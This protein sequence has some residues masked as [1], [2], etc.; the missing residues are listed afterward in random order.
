MNPVNS[1]KIVCP[2]VYFSVQFVW[3]SM[4]AYVYCDFFFLSLT[5]FFLG[6]YFIFALFLLCS[7][8]STRW[9]CFTVYK[10]CSDRRDDRCAVFAYINAD[11]ILVELLLYYYIGFDIFL[12]ISEVLKVL[13][14]RLFCGL[15]IMI[16]IMFFVCIRKTKTCC[17]PLNY[18]QLNG[19]RKTFNQFWDCIWWINERTANEQID[20]RLT[21]KNL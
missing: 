12:I 3:V 6:L 2:V 13:N 16:F 9:S 7:L 15:T 18:I 11:I 19:I 17:F 4:F 10:A 8:N 14:T 21:E 20:Q 5:I 1:P